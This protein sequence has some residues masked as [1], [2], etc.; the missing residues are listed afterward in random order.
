ME[1]CGSHLLFH[2]PLFARASCLTADAFFLFWP[3]DEPRSNYAASLKEKNDFEPL[4]VAAY[5][6]SP[7]SHIPVKWTID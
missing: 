3:Q 1:A 4:V 7:G 5:S 6:V 2:H